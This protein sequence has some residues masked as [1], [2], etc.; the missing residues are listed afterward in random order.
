MT[1]YDFLEK[2]PKIG[3]LI[4]IEGVEKLLADRA[5]AA[6]EERLLA[7]EE[8]DLNLDRIDAPSV[9]SFSRVESAVAALPFLAARRVV[10]VRNCHLLKAAARKAL[11]AV[12]ERVPDGN[13]LVL[14]DL[15]SP[16]KR[17]KPD[18][19]GQLAGRTALRIDSTA[20]AGVR[21]RFIRETLAV[22]GARA[23]R[24]AIAALAGGE[25]DLAAVR[26]DLEKLALAGG[27]IRAEDVLRETLVTIDAKAYRYA[28]ALVEGRAAEALEIAFDLFASDPR[29]AAIP[30]LSAAASEYQALWELARPGGGELP[31]RLRWRERIL[32]PIARRMGERRARLG[33]ERAV[34]GFEAVVTGRAEDPRAV[35]EAVTAAA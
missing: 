25:G 9:E 19:F 26:T 4:V 22:L 7:P 31:A 27:E 18:T 15:Q 3:R 11:W 32:R 20:S 17:T 13:V 14:E 23:D 21:E 34:R 30:L 10:V 33:F 35:V 29:G 8:R 2:P 6:I 16:A 1:V 5:L 24:A 28:S 12:A